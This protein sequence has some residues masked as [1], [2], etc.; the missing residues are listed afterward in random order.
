MGY[1]KW[2]C[3]N[4]L[5]P[6]YCCRCKDLRDLSGLPASF[7]THL[8][9]QLN[10]SNQIGII[11]YFIVLLAMPDTSLNI[12]AIAIAPRVAVRRARIVPM[13]D[14][15]CM[16]SSSWITT[17]PSGRRPCYYSRP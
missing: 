4:P 5:D 14:M 8:L 3:Q 11:W 1:A 15:A 6:T 13:P 9:V 2:V 16:V 10:P 17:C 7:R 12:P